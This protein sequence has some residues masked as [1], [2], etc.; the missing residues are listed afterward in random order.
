[1]KI[2]PRDVSGEMRMALLALERCRR[3]IGKLPAEW[4]AW[5]IESLFESRPVLD[6]E[7]T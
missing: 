5:V 1:M 2:P 7:V 3:E 4:Q 6:H